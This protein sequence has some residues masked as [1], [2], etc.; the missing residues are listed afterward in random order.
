MSSASEAAHALIERC[1]RHLERAPAGYSYYEAWLES[2]EDA[3]QGVTEAVTAAAR[4]A[5]AVADGPVLRS[6][7]QAL[8]CGG[9]AEDVARLRPLAAS[10]DAAVASEASQAIQYI[11]HRMKSLEHLLDEVDSRDAFIAFAEALAKEREAAA[12]LE[13]AEPRRYSI[14]GALDW[15]N[16]DIASFIYAGLTRFQHSRDD[17]Q[18]TWRMFAE[19]LYHGKIIE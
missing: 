10:E 15:K 1:S 19:F 8:A 13:R 18:P 11:E 14:D 6:A 9:D 7:I 5:L 16:G 17:E 4:S 12:R 2:E 3:V